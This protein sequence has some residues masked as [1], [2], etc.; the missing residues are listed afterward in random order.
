MSGGMQRR[1]AIARALAY[2]PP[3]LFFDEPTTGLDPGTGRAI[4]NLI[5]K[6]HQETKKTIIIVTHSPITMRIC[7]RFLFL[8]NGYI[9][10]VDDFD[11]LEGDLK[12]RMDKFLGGHKV[13][14]T[15]T[16]EN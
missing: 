7:K 5:T 3:I 10:N 8:D 16:S 6:I 9:Y 13:A 2:D 15:K 14:L 4:E 12:Q 11:T 1:V